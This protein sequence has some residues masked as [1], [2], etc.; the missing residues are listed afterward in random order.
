MNREKVWGDVGSQEGERERERER[1]I[2]RVRKRKME[3]V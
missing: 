2:L 3:G 1:E